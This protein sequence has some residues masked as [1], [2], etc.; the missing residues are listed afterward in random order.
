M[1]R[2]IYLLVRP[3]G[4]T[5]EKFAEE[6]QVHYDMSHNVP[7]LHKYEVRLVAGEPSNTH[8]PFLDIGPFDAVAEC[9]FESSEKY[10]EYLAS[11][12]RK[13]WFEHGKTFIGQLKPIY[14]QELH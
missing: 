6:C 10:E 7:A 2:I 11:D 4:M 12:I 3:Q 5:P 13:E 14:T 9:W 1:I 8:V